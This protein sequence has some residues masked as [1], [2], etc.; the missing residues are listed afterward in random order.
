MTWTHRD[1][2][3]AALNHEEPDRVPIDF[4]GA[5]FT[6]I[7]LAGYRRLK[8]HLGVTAPTQAMSIIHSVAHPAEAILTRFGVDTRNVQPGAYAGG[9]DHW[10]DDN[11]YVD[12]FGVLWKRTEKDI[13]QHF[14]QKS[15]VRF[16]FQRLT[17]VSDRLLYHC[18]IAYYVLTS[19]R[20][21]ISQL[22]IKV[23]FDVAGS[24][25]VDRFQCVIS[26]KRRA[27]EGQVCRY[28]LHYCLR[29]V[30]CIIFKDGIGNHRRRADQ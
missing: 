17:N 11:A 24:A 10:I 12:I 23:R 4:G 8:D 28:Y 15:I 6:T 22:T 29:R 18:Q 1:R 7:T 16:F 26:T 3:L 27:F 13:D 19:L 20:R 9:V 25:T 14:L 2:T 21:K 30:R 5:E